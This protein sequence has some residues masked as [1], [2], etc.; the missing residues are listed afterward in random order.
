MIE[1]RNEPRTRLMGE[2]D[3]EQMLLRFPCRPLPFIRTGIVFEWKLVGFLI[4]SQVFDE[5]CDK[6]CKGDKLYFC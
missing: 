5:R 6:D 1:R 4:R 3:G 2:R